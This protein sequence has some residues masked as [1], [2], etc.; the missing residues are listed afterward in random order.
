MELKKVE[1]G[2]KRSELFDHSALMK[3]LFQ[4]FGSPVMEKC[5]HMHCVEICRHFTAD[6]LCSVLSP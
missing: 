5:L 4:L 2:M 3:D 1:S 6:H